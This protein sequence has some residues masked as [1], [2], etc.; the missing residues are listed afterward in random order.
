MSLNFAG[1]R[2][3]PAVE[4]QALL[5][6]VTEPA[7]LIAVNGTIVAA[8]AAWRE[9]FGDGARLPKDAPGL[10]A[11][12]LR[13]RRGE[14]C[15][16]VLRRGDVERRVAVGAVGSDRFL[17][18]MTPAA[19]PPTAAWLS[20]KSV[21]RPGAA[22]VDP[23]VAASPFGVALIEGTDPFG[24]PI[25]DANAA[26]SGIVGHAVQ[27]GAKLGELFTPASR[28]EAAAGHAAS[29]PGPFEVVLAG[30]GDKTVHLYL[31]PAEE[32]TAAYLL[33]VTEQKAM[34]LQLAQRHKM[35][36][37]GQLAGGVAHEINNLLSAI[38]L[39]A[40]E[41]LLRHSL[42]DPSYESLAEIRTTVIRAADVVRQLLA[43][44]RQATLRR[45]NL[46]LGEVLSNLDVLLRR[47]LREDVRLETHYG[48]NL[49]R[50]RADKAQVESAVMNLVVNARDA[51]RANG[52]G[53]V[54]LRA[55]RV[56]EA[57]ASD[58]GYVGPAMGEM[59]LIEVADDGA[60]IPPE[61]IGHIFEP[62][63]TT[64][65]LGEGTG[66]GL[67]TVWGIVKQSEGWIGVT[68]TPGEGA[69]FR[70]L[71]PAHLPPLAV[72]PPPGA[73]PRRAAP[74]DLSG[75]GRILFVEDEVLVR[76]VAARLLRARGYE[77]IEAADGEEALAL[78]ELH[79]GTIDLM[80]SDVIMPG[81]DGPTL[82][83]AAR[84]F[85]GAAPVMFISG[86]AE[87]EFSDL[88]EGES[89]VSFLA[90]PLD[91]MSLAERVKEQMR[92]P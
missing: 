20:P 86:Y 3:K 56:S 50:V 15:E 60:G 1:L 39:R 38:L 55:A 91:I 64:K 40:D 8:N 7:S 34:Q 67:A 18:R 87:V 54:R 74:R 46:D 66:L 48:P 73:A 23:F 44:S 2:V 24:D 75:V 78:A 14:R 72:E 51:S 58:M 88:L 36:A 45:E 5:D 4:S 69:A 9:S 12:L 82:L 28:A 17:V 83:K 81:M 31:A 84:R 43:F 68:S 19:P 79:A 57:E 90:K 62:F 30:A 33:D 61:L 10:F 71:L 25:A 59:A 85:L 32:R 76:G 27:P 42:G 47:L 35:E 29:R 52:G 11:A 6:A 21:E 22:G 37:I 70:I 92:P 89:G 13:A 26:L 53:V 63:F 41:L 80:I 77:V 65:A 49:P 16:G